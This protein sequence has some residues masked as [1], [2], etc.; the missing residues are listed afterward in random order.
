MTTNKG[1]NFSIEAADIAALFLAM[2]HSIPGFC[3]SWFLFEQW[4]KGRK[5]KKDPRNFKLS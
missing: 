3:F 2:G 5:A 1:R 4:E